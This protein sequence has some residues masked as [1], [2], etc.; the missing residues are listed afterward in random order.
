MF[1]F[2]KSKIKQQQKTDS[3]GKLFR[4]GKKIYH[5]F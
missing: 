4:R 3:G 1:V 2:M 5:E